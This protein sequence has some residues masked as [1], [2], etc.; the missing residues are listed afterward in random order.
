[1]KTLYTFLAALLLTACVSAE[2]AAELQSWDAW[3]YSWVRVYRYNEWGYPISYYDIYNS[4]ADAGGNPVE[5]SES[6][7]YTYYPDRFRFTFDGTSL[8]VNRF[9]ISTVGGSSST[10]SELI[11]SGRWAVFGWVDDNILTPDPY[12]SLV[13]GRVHWAPN[14]PVGYTANLLL[15][16][17]FEGDG[18]PMY[19]QHPSY[20]YPL[21]Q[22]T[23]LMIR[24]FSP[25]MGYDYPDRYSF[26]SHVFTA[27]Y[28]PE[29]EALAGVMSGITLLA[30]RR[31]VIRKP[32]WHISRLQP[33]G[34]S[35]CRC[36]G[37]A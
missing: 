37:Q 26:K 3:V 19:Q 31:R 23:T 20:I 4:P 6:D 29:P 10:A 18:A 11:L 36:R 22:G 2:C 12:A 33:A 34:S 28:V 35:A 8:T 15:G 24:T 25:R 27:T 5:C 30:A 1:M 16:Y 7:Y 17:R 32:V 13:D 21:Q 9:G 14:T